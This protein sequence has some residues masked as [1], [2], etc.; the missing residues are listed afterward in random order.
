[1]EDGL[2]KT[3]R[4]IVWLS[5][6]YPFKFFKGCPPQIFL[7]P[8]L[9]TLSQFKCCYQPTSFAKESY[10]WNFHDQ[11]YLWHISNNNWSVK[12][13]FKMSKSQWSSQICYWWIV[14]LKIGGLKLDC[15]WISLQV[16]FKN[17]SQI[18]SILKERIL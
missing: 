11:A 3:W 2:W 5:R 10:F 14:K 1:M 8:F 12:A 16:V 13:S 15:K 7:I 17:L 18:F 4:D 6:P 9:N